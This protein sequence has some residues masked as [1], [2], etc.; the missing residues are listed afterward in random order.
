MANI[1][2]EVLTARVIEYLEK[3]NTFPWRKTWSIG[4]VDNLQYNLITHKKPYSGINAIM[5]TLQCFPSRFWLTFKQAQA[6]GLQLTKG[7]KGTPIVY[8]LIKDKPTGVNPDGSVATKKTFTPF[9]STIFNLSQ[10][11]DWESVKTP[12]TGKPEAAPKVV[13]LLEA[14][15]SVLKGY[16]NAPA[17]S[18]GHDRACYSPALDKVMMP[19]INQFESAEEY[20]STHFHEF[21]HSTGHE[22]KLARKGIIAMDGFGSKTYSFEELIAEIGASI[23]C[24]YSG[25]NSEK[26]LDNSAAY[27]MNWISVLK[28]DVSLLPKAAAAAQKAAN[29]I[30]GFNP[31]DM[32]EE[33]ESDSEVVTEA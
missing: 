25:I 21:I 27:V 32:E 29:L 7:S 9:Y 17:T 15:E 18:Y 8:W 23:L 4:N 19:S 22:K 28:K 24:N 33:P 2:Y 1:A 6:K 3:G 26:V 20:Y 12:D 10:F 13:D 30:L 16:K 5:T 31:N 11:K 14:G